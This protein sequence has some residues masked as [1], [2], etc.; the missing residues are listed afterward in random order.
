MAPGPVQHAGNGRLSAAGKSVKNIADGLHPKFPKRVYN[1]DEMDFTTQHD[2]RD[3]KG[4]KGKRGP[5]RQNKEENVSSSI[6][7]QLLSGII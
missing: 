1:G 2:T 4:R 3:W 5:W 6:Y 7:S